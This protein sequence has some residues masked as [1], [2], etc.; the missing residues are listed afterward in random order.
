MCKVSQSVLKKL[1]D[2]IQFRGRLSSLELWD[3]QCNWIF[4]GA[5]PPLVQCMMLWAKMSSHSKAGQMIHD[6]EGGRGQSNLA[7]HSIPPT[8][9][10]ITT[11]SHITL[12]FKIS[13]KNCNLKSINC[14]S[15]CSKPFH[16]NSIWT[17]VEHKIKCFTLHNA[18]TSL[19]NVHRLKT[20]FWE[21]RVSGGRWGWCS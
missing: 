11:T 4:C 17:R 8:Q 18:A 19:Q 9:I 14:R 13:T 5:A 21:W 7:T 3:I 6:W 12:V 1:S 16:S 2:E 20:E 15:F 10:Q